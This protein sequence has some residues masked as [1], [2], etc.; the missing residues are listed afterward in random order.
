MRGTD[1]LHLLL[2]AEGDPETPDSWS[3]TS[4]RI[5][6]G[7]RAAGHTV[8]TADCE[9]TGLGRLSAL[10]LTWHPSRPRWWVR[11][12]LGSVG[13]R[14]RSALAQA[15]ID[16]HPKIDLIVQVGATF[17]PR[18][19]VHKSLVVL[20]DGN[21]VL[22]EAAAGVAATDAAFLSARERTRVRVRE[23]RVYDVADL[24]ISL[25]DR[26]ARSCVED[27]GVPAE[28]VR[29]MYAG[30]NIDAGRFGDTLPIPQDVPP[31]ILFVGRQWERKGG[32]VLIRVFARVRARVPDARLVVI[33]PRLVSPLPAGVEFLGLVDK[34][35]PA[36]WERIR[37]AYVEASVFCLP[38]RFEGFAI[39]VLEAMMFGRPCV[40]CRFPWMESE[41]VEDGVTGYVIEG[42]DELQLEQRLV[43]LLTDKKSAEGMGQVAA[44]R[45]RD[46]YNWP[47]AIGRLERALTDLGIRRAF[48]TA[49]GRD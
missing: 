7:L 26:V 39:S 24:V 5:V 28:R 33:G 6:E 42:S 47:A 19:A 30:P 25:S 44:S 21:I 34:E 4:R 31:T 43:T 16:A 2:L 35:S 3:G 18:V 27:F 29:T 11:Y 32:D 1:R 46:R 36:G 13:F 14:M 8:T 45:V 37:R 40:T 15:V 10:A 22:S 17:L 23:Q 20:T 38:S 49:S 41:M 12:H 48:A 9:L